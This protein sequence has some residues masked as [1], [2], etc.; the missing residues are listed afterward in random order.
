LD[1]STVLLSPLHQ[2]RQL[3]GYLK[4]DTISY[5]DDVIHTMTTQIDELY[6]K[7]TSYTNN[8]F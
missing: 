6:T 8:I 7:I 4:N 5:Y 2:N 3:G 1:F